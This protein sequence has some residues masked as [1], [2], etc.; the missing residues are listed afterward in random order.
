[1]DGLMQNELQNELQNKETL[2]NILNAINKSNVIN[3][4]N[5]K[6]MANVANIQKIGLLLNG[7]NLCA[8][9]AGF[10]IIYAKLE[11][12]SAEIGQQIDKVK[13][14][15]KQGQ[16]VQIDYEFNKV[17][18]DHT[19][20]LDCRR[21]QQP[22]SE[23]RMRDLVDREYNVLS[24]LINVFQKDISANNEA[25]IFSIF[26]LLSMFTVSL[27]YFDEIYYTNNHEVLGED[28]LWHTSHDKWLGIYETL[29]SQQFIEKLQDYAAFE[30]N[31]NT[32][33][34]D[35]YC[36]NLTDYVIDRKEVIEDNQT[37]IAALGDV[38][39]LDKFDEMINKANQL[40]ERGNKFEALK[41]YENIAVYNQSLSNYNLG[42]SQMKQERCDEA[43]I[44]FNKAINSLT[45]AGKIFFIAWGTIIFLIVCE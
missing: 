41:I 44:S 3:E 21:K 25:I 17:L 1:V 9:C 20:M 22:Y 14:L 35:A 18:A 5:L 30:T 31:M 15:I 45:K 39:L 34:I 26:A 6:L 42:V 43:I 40:Y 19:D 33:E 37:L 10:A 32:L 7:L 12:M 23:E 28:E 16:D 38:S 27:K 13:N 24:L 11:K 36:K 29:S 2:E 8:T 4:K